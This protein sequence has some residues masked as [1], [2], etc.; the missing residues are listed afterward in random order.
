MHKQRTS[1]CNVLMQ[2]SLTSR[3]IQRCFPACRRC[4]RGFRRR[5]TPGARPANWRMSPESTELPGPG[6]RVFRLQGGRE[7]IPAAVAGSSD[8]RI[9]PLHRVFPLFRIRMPMQSRRRFRTLELKQ[10]A[11]TL[12]LKAYRCSDCSVLKPVVSSCI[13]THG[14]RV[15]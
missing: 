9:C 13:A 8:L 10:R 4:N 12:R 14:T 2:E 5:Q 3:G 6:H 1:K 7:T 15:Q 11:R